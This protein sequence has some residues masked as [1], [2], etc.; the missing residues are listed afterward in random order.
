MLFSTRYTVQERAFFL[1]THLRPLPD[2]TVSIIGEPFAGGSST[3]MVTF[4]NDR[5]C[6]VEIM[7][8]MVAR[9][10]AFAFAADTVVAPTEVNAMTVPTATQ[11]ILRFISLNPFRHYWRVWIQ[12]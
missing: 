8:T 7:R 1:M 9:P 5:V 3:V 6:F 10:G 4:D 11:A 12:R 2:T